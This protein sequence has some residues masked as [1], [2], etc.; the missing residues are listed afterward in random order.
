V[1]DPAADRWNSS[2]AMPTARHGLDSA[3]DDERWYVVGGGTGAGVRTFLTLTSLN[4]VY[5]N[6][7]KK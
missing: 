5:T 1:Y 7:K 6:R 3:A 2:L 4:E